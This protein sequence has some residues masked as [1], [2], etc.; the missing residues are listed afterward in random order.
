MTRKTHQR[1]VI[2]DLFM[3]ALLMILTTF[4]VYYGATRNRVP[5]LLA[6]QC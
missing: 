5:F 3:L 4:G 2:I 1:L 6:S